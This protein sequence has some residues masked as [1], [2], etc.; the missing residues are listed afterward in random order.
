MGRTIRLAAASAAVTA[1]CITIAAPAAADND[2]YL[3]ALGDRVH[4][5]NGPEGLLAVGKEACRLL[6]PNNAMMF[7]RAPNVVSRMI[8][9]A[10]PMLERDQADFIV[11]T[12]NTHL[13]PGIN[14]FAPG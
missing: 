13:C 12:A 1:A 10:A 9:E 14:P 4:S 6:A 7:G 8:W 2:S 3:A 5:T 11:A